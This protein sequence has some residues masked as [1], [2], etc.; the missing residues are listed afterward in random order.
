MTPCRRPGVVAAFLGSTLALAACRDAETERTFL[1]TDSA[2]VE[3]AFSAVPAA[4]G[5]ERWSI[6]A[7]PVLEI[8][9]DPADSAA[10]L[11]RVVGI[12]LLPDG[13]VAVANLGDNTIRFYD[14]QGALLRKVGGSGEGP[15]EF[16][17]IRG[18]AHRGGELW[19]YQI[20]P[21]PT[22]V[23]DLQGTF[24]RSVRMPPITG[25]RLHG[26]L[27]DGSVIASVSQRTSRTETSTDSAA[28]IRFGS[29]GLDTI[30]VLPALKRIAIDGIGTEAQALGPTL[31]VAADDS[32]VYTSFSSSWDIA[33]WRDTTLVRRVR[34]GATPTTVTADH[35]EA[36]RAALRSE[37][38]D[39]PRI[40]QAY[41][42]L[43][44]QMVFPDHHPLQSRLMLDRSGMLWVERPQTEP[45]YSEA[46]DYAS[47]PAHVSTWDVISKAGEWL[48][49][50]ILPA[51]FR[52]LEI[53]DD[54]VAG[55]AKD[56]LDVESILVLGLDRSE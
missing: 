47:V 37:G 28:V 48:T 15:G 6:S 17:Q 21:H 45:P 18:L 9:P 54:Y 26:F 51:R 41:Q 11:Y 40:R 23:F 52:V 27:A 34:I 2:G 55:V 20:L 7:E 4:I 8:Q 5:D 44:D 19:A 31:F 16:R 50:V 29:A 10:L 24:L 39:D 14:A 22:L 36:Y 46:I 38:G 25:P 42:Q 32:L 56:D 12:S 13:R 33:V 3:L 43:A 1:V 35:R 30:A 53:G 49:T